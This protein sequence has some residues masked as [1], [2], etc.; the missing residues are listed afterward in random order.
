[1]SVLD[2]KNT[3]YHV[4]SNF[5]YN[6]L[7]LHPMYLSLLLLLDNLLIFDG[8]L[9]L[10]VSQIQSTKYSDLYSPR[11]FVYFRSLSYSINNNDSQAVTCHVIS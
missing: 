11:Y 5:Y 10:S 3:H 2:Y 8:S 4:L 1:M 6:D 9:V 7:Y